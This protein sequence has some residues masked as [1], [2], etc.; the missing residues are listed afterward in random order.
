ME[1]RKKG[2]AATYAAPGNSG[3]SKS[4]LA[5]GVKS[6]T[7]LA[8]RFHALFAGLERAHG[9]YNNIDQTRDDGKRTSLNPLTLRDPVTNELWEKHLTGA[10]CIGIIPVRDDSTCVFGAID[11]DVYD[12][13]NHGY[14]A[15]QCQRLGLP[16]VVCRSKSG[17]AHLYLFCAQPTPAQKVQERLR[18]IAAQLGFG[19]AEIFP[20]QTRIHSEKDLGSW[21]NAPY[22]NAHETNRYA[23]KANG[24]ALLVEEFLALAESSKVQPEWFDLPLPKVS[25]PAKPQKSKSRRTFILPDQITEGQ[26]DI[27]LT[28]YA[29]VL[30]RTGED[31]EGILAA[32]R[33]ANQKR[34][35]PPMTDKQ[36]EKIAGSIGKKEA[37]AEVEDGLIQ[38]MAGAIL[39]T[40]AFARDAGGLLYR[41]DKG[42]SSKPLARRTLRVPGKAALI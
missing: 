18:D 31:R 25:A 14:I 15:V 5:P 8:A 11:I 32:L 2:A 37:G 38:T 35:V 9:V 17:G 39:A 16:L 30:R 41:Y 27:V 4:I 1:S 6:L 36:L 40:D 20:K 12:G 42:V 29:G 34:C 21:I 23:V 33:T 22:A 7:S 19:N 24:D 26:R 10:N 3:Q 28:R 13:L